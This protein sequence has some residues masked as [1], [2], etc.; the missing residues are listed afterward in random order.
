MNA[1]AVYS[2]D[3][4]SFAY[5]GAKLEPIDYEVGSGETLVVP[6]SNLAKRKFNVVTQKWTGE[7][8]IFSPT[9]EQKTL[10]QQSQQI[11]VLQAL[12]MQ[13]DQANAKSQATNAQQAAQIK[14]LQ[15]M[16]MTANQQQ[17]VEKAKEVTAQ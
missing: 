3:Q 2:F 9:L 14:Q 6:P 4:E 8:V 1:K 7:K 5:L 15:Q 13:Q 17:A 16:F 11:T 10:M 12:I